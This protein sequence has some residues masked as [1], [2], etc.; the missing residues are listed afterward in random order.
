[1]TQ[2]NLEDFAKEIKNMTGND[3]IIAEMVLALCYYTMAKD[4]LQKHHLK[5]IEDH[6]KSLYKLLSVIASNWNP[7]YQI[8]QEEPEEN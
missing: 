7:I 1:M 8:E 3:K 2:L 6:T 5:S 4:K